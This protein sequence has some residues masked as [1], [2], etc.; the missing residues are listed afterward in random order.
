MTENET[1]DKTE[2]IIIEN[3]IESRRLNRSKIE[4]EI[5]YAENGIETE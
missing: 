2:K 5:E 1:N 4:L 3:T